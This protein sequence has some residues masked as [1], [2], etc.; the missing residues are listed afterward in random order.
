MEK[1]LRVGEDEAREKTVG[2]NGNQ[3]IEQDGVESRGNPMGKKQFPENPDSDNLKKGP[4]GND[5]GENQVSPEGCGSKK[6]YPER[7]DSRQNQPT[8]DDQADGDFIAVKLGQKLSNGENLGGDGGYPN[9]DDGPDHES[10]KTSGGKVFHEAVL[11]LKGLYLIGGNIKI[12]FF[13]SVFIK[14]RFEAEVIQKRLF[15][16]QLIPYLGQKGGLVK[17]LLDDHPV[18]ARSKLGQEII[19][20]AIG[21]GFWFGQNADFNSYIFPFIHGKRTKSGVPKCGIDGID[22]DSL[23]Q[24]FLGNDVPDTTPQV[25]SDGQG[26]KRT[27]GLIKHRRQVNFLFGGFL[28][29]GNGCLNGFPCL[30]KQIFAFSF[31]QTPFFRHAFLPCSVFV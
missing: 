28:F 3:D 24:G 2:S 16:R 7:S 15:I 9:S 23:N 18:N 12:T 22:P 13:P 6:L 27:P 31:G 10:A 11:F 26:H 8:E 1:L 20:I 17:S 21:E 5:E 30:G 25:A 4:D 14:A 29:A 19:P